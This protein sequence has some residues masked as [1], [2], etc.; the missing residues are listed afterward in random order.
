MS[1]IKDIYKCNPIKKRKLLPL[2]IWY[3]KVI[4]KEYS[5]IDLDDVLRMFRQEVFIETAVKKSIDYLK[6]DPVMGEMY[7]G[8]LLEKLLSEKD[9]LYLDYREDLIIIT[10]G[11]EEKLSNHD[12]LT[13]EE[14]SIFCMCLKRI[15]EELDDY[16]N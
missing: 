8:E 12:W 15:K 13:E 5:E 6:R 9:K 2:E 1:K 16:N 10:E 4:E 3:N 7:D 11:A 14:K